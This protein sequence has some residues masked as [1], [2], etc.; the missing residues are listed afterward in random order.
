MPQV[1]TYT[2][3]TG[4]ETIDPDVFLGC[5]VGVLRQLE[6][7]DGARRVSGAQQ[8]TQGAAAGAQVQDLGG[9]WQLYKV[10][11][12]HGV[13]AQ[14]KATWRDLQGKAVKK[15]LQRNAPL[16]NRPARKTRRPSVCEDLA[17]LDSFGGAL[18]GAGAA[19]D[20]DIRIDGF[21]LEIPPR[22][23]R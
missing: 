5:P 16:K 4:L 2:L 19:A 7:G 23:H 10:S 13:R 6:A 22:K 12:D 21:T 3:H 14:G 1:R 17:F 11:Q 15:C 20:A 8:H 18:V 9:S